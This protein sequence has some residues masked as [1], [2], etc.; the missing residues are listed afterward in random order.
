MATMTRQ[1]FHTAGLVIVGVAPGIGSAQARN[2][3]GGS[4][5][6]TNIDEPE[7]LNRVQAV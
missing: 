1:V 5:D 3:V 2:V 4:G 7:C 6:P